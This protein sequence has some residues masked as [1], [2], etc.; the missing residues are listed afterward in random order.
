M[1]EIKNSNSKMRIVI[2]GFLMFYPNILGAVFGLVLARLING[3]DSTYMV[4]S[5]LF[6]LLGGI[7]KNMF[8]DGMKP[9]ES[10]LRNLL[11]VFAGII[12]I[13]IK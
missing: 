5:G 3:Q 8:V 1:L 7:L 10:L 9:A 11:I 2:D 6:A 4:F 13:L 12:L